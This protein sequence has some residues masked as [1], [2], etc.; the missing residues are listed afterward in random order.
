LS[1]IRPAHKELFLDNAAPGQRGFYS[2]HHAYDLIL[3]GGGHYEV[4]KGKTVT[5]EI[6][7]TKQY[8][9]STPGKYTIRVFHPDREANIDVQSTNTINLTVTE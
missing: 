2:D 4:E 7:V 8:D 9:L 1:G 6:E 3:G 5:E